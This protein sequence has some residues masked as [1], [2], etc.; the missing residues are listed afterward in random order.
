MKKKSDN[1]MNCYEMQSE[2]I[3]SRELEV[4]RRKGQQKFGKINL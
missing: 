3:K 2:A 1:E 4:E